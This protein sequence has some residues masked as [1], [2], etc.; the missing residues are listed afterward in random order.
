[1]RRKQLVNTLEEALELPKDK[2]ERLCRHAGIASTRRGETLTLDEF[3]KLARAAA[4]Y[5]GTEPT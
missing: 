4:D 5:V 2:V 3:A 1:M